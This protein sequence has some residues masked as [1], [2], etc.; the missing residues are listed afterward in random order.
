MRVGA[1]A[2]S[3]RVGRLDQV[4]HVGVRHPSPQVGTRRG[5]SKPGRTR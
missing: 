3:V 1:H 4:G 2:R 5:R